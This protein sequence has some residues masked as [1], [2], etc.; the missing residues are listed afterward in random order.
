MKNRKLI[1]THQLFKDALIEMLHTK[2]ISEISITK[3][4]EKANLNRSTFY[5]HYQTPLDILHELETDTLNE[6]K[7][8]LHI[9][10][11]SISSSDTEKLFYYILNFVKKHK[12]LF[13]VLFGENCPRTF[14]KQ[15]LEYLQQIFPNPNITRMS[16]TERNYIYLYNTLGTI[17][18]IIRWLRNGT[19]EAEEDMAKLLSK[20]Y[21]E[22]F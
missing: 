6:I 8:Y 11:D 21:R 1:L 22:T 16:D 13:L 9:V 20:L 15:F 3:L 14:T 4:C 7:S 12:D 10:D 5:A 18:I 19:L 17:S 2:H